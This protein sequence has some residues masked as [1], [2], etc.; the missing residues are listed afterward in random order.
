MK[1]VALALLAALAMVQSAVATPLTMTYTVSGQ[2]TYA[3]DF[4]LTLDNHDGSWNAGEGFNWITFG[5]VV[6]LN[7]VQGAFT[8]GFA[9]DMAKFHAAP[10]SAT[11][12][13]GYHNGPTLLDLN[14]IM[15]GWTPNAVGASISW[16]GTSSTYLGQGQLVWS[17]LIGQGS[18]R[19]DF[20]VANMAAAQVPEP[21]SIALLA[22][23]LLGFGA[24]A[25]RKN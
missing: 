12:S 14:N 3:Y 11:N 21:T 5:D 20:E 10:L 9:F 16:S 18:N 24:V 19:A 13:V 17:N 7:N 25:R 23:A 6:M 8:S 2:G 4:L 15:Q 1:R 22:I